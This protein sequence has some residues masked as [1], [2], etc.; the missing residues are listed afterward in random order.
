MN[1]DQ[2]LSLVCLGGTVVFLYQL[3]EILS[4]H[5]TWAEFQTP[6]GVGELVLC[7]AAGLAAVAAA[8][9]INMSNVFG[10]K[11]QP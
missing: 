6:A 7:V 1:K 4:Q 3:A 10:T 8:L 5:T 2:K 9:G 11:E